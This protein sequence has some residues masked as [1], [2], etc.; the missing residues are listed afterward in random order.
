MDSNTSFSMQGYS[1]STSVSVNPNSL[2][3]RRPSMMDKV[4][5]SPGLE[6]GAKFTCRPL[7][8]LR[9]AKEIRCWRVV[10]TVANL[11]LSLSHWVILGLQL[12]HVSGDQPAPVS[13]MSIELLETET[14]HQLVE[15]ACSTNGIKTCSYEGRGRNFTVT[16]NS[17]ENYNHS[18]T[19]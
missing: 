16:A 8:V 14:L 9:R 3:K 6:G 2:G 19:S 17:T 13:S 10:W 4:T 18:T 11:D 1:R 12:S 15:D 5:S 7:T